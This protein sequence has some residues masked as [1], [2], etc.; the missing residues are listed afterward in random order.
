[1]ANKTRADIIAQLKEYIP[2][3]NATAHDAAVDNLIDLSAEH[4]SGRHNFS[5]LRATSP[6]THD[7]AANEYYMDESDFSFTN[8]KEIYFLEWIKAATGENAR[9]EWLPENEFRR[10]FRYV[11]YSGKADGKPAFYTRS[12][13]RFFFNCQFDEAATIRAWY[14]KYHGAFAGDSTSHSF[15]PDMIGFNAIVAV[16]LAESQTMIPGL[17]LNPKAQSA[18]GTAEYWI[19]QLVQADIGKNEEGVKLAPKQYRRGSGGETSPYDW[20][21]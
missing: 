4:I 15:Q 21:A 19:S 12:G 2:N 14:Q 9:I 5:Y 3:L 10:R 17:V 6:A 16:A 8:L 13:N 7:A 11:E 1:M 20:V 18:A